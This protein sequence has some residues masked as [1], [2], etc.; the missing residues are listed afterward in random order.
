[1]IACPEIQPSST[2]SSI[3]EA[4][5]GFENLQR[6]ML[7]WNSKLKQCIF[8]TAMHSICIGVKLVGN[9]SLERMSLMLF[10][11]NQRYVFFI[12]HLH[13][14]SSISALTKDPI[15]YATVAQVPPRTNVSQPLQTQ[16]VR[17]QRYRKNHYTASNKEER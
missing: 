2:E 17:L 16:F 10:I 11:Q 5:S 14:S 13:S 12:F 9:L 8:D 15:E 3:S 6:F 1:M 4:Q 7:G